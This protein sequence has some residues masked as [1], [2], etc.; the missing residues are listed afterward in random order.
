MFQNVMVTPAIPERVFAL[1][2]VVEKKAL[3]SAELRDKLEPDFLK[4]NSS[5]YQDYK[6]AAEELGLISISDHIISLAVDPAYISSIDQMRYYINCRLESYQNGQFYK[7]TRAY[8]F[9]EEQVLHG[10]KNV[11]NMA[12]LMSQKTGVAVDSMAMRAWRFWASFLG[13]GYLQ[14]MFVIPNSSVFLS[15]LIR[16]ANLVKNQR[17]SMSEF[18]GCMHPYSNIIMDSANTSKRFNYGVSNG[19]RTLHDDGYIKLEHIMDQQD[20]WSL[21]PMNAH[22][23]RGTVTNI[24]ILR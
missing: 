4:N 3:S 12:S 11:A 22:S 19:L 23:I 17:Y 1:C 20:I 10:E 21:Y 18:I 16:R 6:N 8:F 15:D 24:T 2:K 7:V 9:M 14:D 5:Y 13:F